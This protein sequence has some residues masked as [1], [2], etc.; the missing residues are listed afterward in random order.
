MRSPNGPHI[1]EALAKASDYVRGVAGDCE[2]RENLKVATD[3]RASLSK[4]TH[5]SKQEILK[6]VGD[7][8]RKCPK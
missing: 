8:E 7:I 4:V 5:P 3:I 6:A 1:G 2:T